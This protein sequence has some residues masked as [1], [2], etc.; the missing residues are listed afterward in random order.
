VKNL[1]HDIQLQGHS[2]DEED[3]VLNH[4]HYEEQEQQML[5]QQEEVGQKEKL[6]SISL[7]AIESIQGEDY[8]T[9]CDHWRSSSIFIAYEGDDVES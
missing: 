5:P 4:H 1:L 6:M 7:T 2:D 3:R 9:M 8:F